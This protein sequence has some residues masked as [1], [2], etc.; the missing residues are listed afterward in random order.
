MYS[1]PSKKYKEQ[2]KGNFPQITLV[3]WKQV[4]K[5]YNKY[6]TLTELFKTIGNLNLEAKF[7]KDMNLIDFLTALRGMDIYIVLR[8]VLLIPEFWLSRHDIISIQNTKTEMENYKS[9][10]SNP[11]VTSGNITAFASLT[12]PYLPPKPI[13]YNPP[14]HKYWASE[15][16]ELLDSCDVI[17]D[18][19]NRTFS[20]RE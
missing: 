7:I 17:Y 15:L 8:D 4:E 14:E 16:V 13:V 12:N 19:E 9:K 1:N 2:K 3:V 18:K 11:F 6:Y 10:S 5:M 20:T